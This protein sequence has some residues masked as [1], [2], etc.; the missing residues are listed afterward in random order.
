VNVLQ[1]PK[2]GADLNELNPTCECCVQPVADHPTNESA[3]AEELEQ[4][5]HEDLLR[6]F[7]GKNHAYYMKNWE[8]KNS[9]NGA[10]FLVAP[11][12]LGYRK[13]YGYVFLYA[14][15]VF[16]L[17][18]LLLLSDFSDWMNFFFSLGL[19]VFTGFKGNDLYRRNAENHI[20]RLQGNYNNAADLEHQVE[21]TGGTSGAGA[22]LAFLVMFA[23]TMFRQE[24][25]GF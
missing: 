2:C 20:A 9:W 10:A 16:L 11:L 7:V 22:F 18:Y 8:Q 1:C 19:A 21:T 14:I 17:N 15:A 24:M 25:L 12:W 4:N 3:A 6:L 5:S 13:M 23:Y